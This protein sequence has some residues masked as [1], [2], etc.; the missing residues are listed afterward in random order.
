MPLYGKPPWEPEERPTLQSVHV[1]GLELSVG[2]RVRLAPKRQADAFD[3]FLAGRTATIQAIERD[4]E[5]RIHLAVTVDD[6]PG[7]DFGIDRKPGHRFFFSPEDIE[8]LDDSS[9]EQRGEA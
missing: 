3:M 1:N 9:I 7:Q 8:P 4:F 2:D 5:N 6:D